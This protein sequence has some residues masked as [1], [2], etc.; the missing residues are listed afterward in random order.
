MITKIGLNCIASFENLETLETDKKINL[1]YGLNGTGKSTLSNYLY[2]KTCTEFSDC[3]IE[4]L[5]DE[6]IL[7]YNQKF[8]HD[9]FYESDNLKGIFTL[10]KENKEAEEKIRNAQKE[11]QKYDQ[12]KIDKVKDK[13]R[14]NGQLSRKKQDAENK[15]WE[16]KTTFTGG[17]RV[18]E[19]CL[20]GL[21]GKKEKLY[22]HISTVSK[23]S[24][25]PEKTT[26]QLKKE[27]E[28][29]KDENAQKFN[30]VPLINFKGSSIES[31]TLFHKVIIGNEN[32]SV[33]E[34]IKSLDNQDWVKKGLDYLPKEIDDSG[35]L[36][37]F[38]QNR[39]ITLA[40][41]S[42]IRDYFN[43][44]YENEIGKLRELRSNYETATNSIQSKETYETNPFI[45]ESKTQFDNLYSRVL[46]L[47][48]RRDRLF[49]NISCITLTTVLWRNQTE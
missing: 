45:I 34:L 33:A 27:V 30:S 47:T 5:N 29:L 21:K 46:K 37:P 10:S 7:V 48:I 24:Q 1:I 9:Y 22:S 35:A 31:D 14:I 3:T 49:I 13:D 41:V 25:K 12:E 16:I 17:D 15:I 32:S 6:I 2:D 4:G 42:N 36:C 19:F 20:D 28:P 43:E 40:V 38:C 26:E 18:L 8:I 39:T 44:T 11:I 23:P